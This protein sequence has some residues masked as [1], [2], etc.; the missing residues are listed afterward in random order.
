MS[1]TNL[2]Q[3][4]QPSSTAFVMQRTLSTTEPIGTVASTMTTGSRQGH[5][6]ATQRGGRGTN[7]VLPPRG[8]RSR[9]AAVKRRDEEV[10]EFYRSAAAARTLEKR[11]LVPFTELAPCSCILNI[12]I[13]IPSCEP[14]SYGGFRESWCSG[15]FQYT[16]VIALLFYIIFRSTCS[17]A[18][19]IAESFKRGRLRIE[20]LDM[21]QA[22]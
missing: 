5:C 8:K 17:M 4:K 16:F 9:K 14:F 15:I 7:K 11:K 13:Y 19:T 18:E 12:E 1:N 21:Y 2:Q 22:Q 20:L 3:P 6:Q 10:E